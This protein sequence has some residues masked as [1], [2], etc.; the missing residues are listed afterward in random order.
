M[1]LLAHLLEHM[2]DVT[3]YTMQII[4]ELGFFQVVKLVLR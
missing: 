4:Q 1:S 2:L 3:S